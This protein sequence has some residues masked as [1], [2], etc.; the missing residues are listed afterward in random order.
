MLLTVDGISSEIL[1]F[2]RSVSDGRFSVSRPFRNCSSNFKSPGDRRSLML[3]NDHLLYSRAD[4]ENINW[5]GM[6]TARNIF[7][8]IFYILKGDYPRRG[9][10]NNNE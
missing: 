10:V 7:A 3:F 2:K 8:Y 6:Q 9:V 1:F 5:I 4:P